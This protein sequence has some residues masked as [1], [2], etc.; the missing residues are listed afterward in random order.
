MAPSLDSITH[1]SSIFAHNNPS[2]M[3]SHNT[4]IH[5]TIPSGVDEAESQ[6]SDSATSP[7]TLSS[8]NS[9]LGAHELDSSTS[10]RHVCTQSLADIYAATSFS[11]ALQEETPIDP[12]SIPPIEDGLPLSVI[13]ALSSSEGPSWNAAI[14]DKLYALHMADTWELV[15]P[16]KHFNFVCCKWLLEK[17]YHPDGRVDRYKARLVACGFTQRYGVHYFDTY[18][19]VLGMA[20]FCMLV[21]IAAKFNMPLHHLDVQT[22]FFHGNLCEEVY[23]AQPPHFADR[24]F[25]HYVCKLKKPIYGLKQSPRQWYTRM[26]NYLLSSGWQRLTVDYNIYIWQSTD[27]LA[28]LGLF[29][30]DIP[31]TGT[32]E[33]MVMR[34]I[35]CLQHEF[36]ITD[37]GPMTY[38]LGIEVLRHPEG[39]WIKLSQSKYI[40]ELLLYYGMGSTSFESAPL[41]LKHNLA[42]EFHGYTPF[43]SLFWPSLHFPRF[44]GQLCYLISCTRFDLCYTG[45]ILSRSM[46]KP[47]KVQKQAAK[48]TLRY[49]STTRNYVL[50]YHYDPATHIFIS[51]YADANWAG[52]DPR[53]FSTGGYVFLLAGGPISSGKHPSLV[54]PQKSSMYQLLSLLVKPFGYISC[55]M[56]SLYPIL[57][58][59]TLW[60][61]TVIIN[62]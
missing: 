16:P 11:V 47:C 9:S 12:L 27:G 60:C 55:Y 18:S 52:D 17:K 50:T 34:A 15:P 21:A 57:S 29:A 37:K 4:P 44:C 46:S 35:D 2:P 8:S 42:P 31:L 45:H 39:K 48:H 25:P 28:L 14:L 43:D 19:P 58:P 62:Q 23:M 53:C 13:D 36:P 26:H 54:L 20:S 22:T 5:Y 38:F 56:S 24:N 59:M 41:P 49:L 3:D 33:L 30:G 32:N 7:A 6:S 51:R 40:D 61:S 10:S 1:T